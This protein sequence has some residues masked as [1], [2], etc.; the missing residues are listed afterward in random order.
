LASTRPSLKNDVFDDIQDWMDHRKAQIAQLAL[1]AEAAG[2]KAWNDATR[3]GQTVAAPTHAALKALGV[4]RPERPN[5]PQSTY[6]LN[7]TAVQ[8]SGRAA[9]TVGNGFG[10]VRG[11]WHSAEGLGKAADFVGR[12][13]DPYDAEQY[14]A[15]QSAWGQ[16]YG[17]A[18]SSVGYLKNGFTDPSGVIRDIKDGAHKINLAN[19][20][21]ATPMADTFGGEMRRR[22]AIGANEGELGWDAGSTLY[23]GAA[24]KALRGLGALDEAAGT[25]KFIG[26]GFT[27][28]QA[29][30]LAAPYEDGMGH[31]FVPLSVAAKRG[32]P[33]AFTESSF[34]V[35]KPNNISRGDFYELH[36]RVDPR[37]HV[38][39]LPKKVGGGLWSGD[40]LGIPKYG[41]LGRLWYGSPAPL[42]AAYGA[43]GLAG[44]GNH[45]DADNPQ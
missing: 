10:V 16:L 43:A 40:D 6:G 19:N 23:G 39:R 9:Q 18:S 27:P 38:A 7:P 5:L 32:L 2:R 33:K 41:L 12:L 31:H 15:D 20:P 44:F 11:V 37:F 1:D 30:H 34:N 14:G 28:A 29:A 17:A 36:Y 13:L 22:F 42:N 3:A 45:P 26:K 25:A 35:L 8:T 24:S 4:E 21:S